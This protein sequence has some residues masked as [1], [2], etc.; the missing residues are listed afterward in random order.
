MPQAAGFFCGRVGYI[1]NAGPLRRSERRAQTVLFSMGVRSTNGRL[2]PKESKTFCRDHV[3]TET[4]LQLPRPS[5]TAE[6]VRV[7]QLPGR[8]LVSSCGETRLALSA[9]R[10]PSSA[11]AALRDPRVIRV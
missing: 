2:L 11:L 4:R 9:N 8:R 6:R 7:G 5:A 3:T 1:G 10:R